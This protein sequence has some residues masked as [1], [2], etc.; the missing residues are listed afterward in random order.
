MHAINLL[1]CYRVALLQ[2]PATLYP[3]S[4]LGRLPSSP[5]GQTN[6]PFLPGLM[7]SFVSWEKVPAQIDSTASSLQSLCALSLLVSHYQRLST[8]VSPPLE[9][10]SAARSPQN[11]P[12][13]FVELALAKW[14]STQIAMPTPGTLLLYHSIHLSMYSDFTEIGRLAHSTLLLNTSNAQSRRPGE[15]S[16]MGATHVSDNSCQSVRE[17]SEK[18]VWHAQRIF[19]LARE[20]EL[21]PSHTS[22]DRIHLLHQAR[23]NTGDPTHYSHAV[24]H[25]AMVLWWTATTDRIRGQLLEPEDNRTSTAQILRRGKVLLS[26]SASQVAR[27]FKQILES[28]EELSL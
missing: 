8:T 15:T 3:L 21:N 2:R 23:K 20:M 1:E 18:A 9:S 26:R 6:S 7:R 17:N 19:K 12:K 5:E 22:G 25:A 11:W 16:C 14:L 28:L 27:V 13:E 4:P 10:Q 24:Y